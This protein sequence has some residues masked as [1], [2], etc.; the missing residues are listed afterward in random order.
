MISLLFVLFL[1]A[2][3]C[4]VLDREKLFFVT[5]SIALAVSLFWFHHHAT[6]PLA[7]QI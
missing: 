4:I 1:A 3:I 5:F 6:T 2:M 7:I